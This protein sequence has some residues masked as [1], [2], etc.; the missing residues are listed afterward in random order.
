[1]RLA[2]LAGLYVAVVC[3]AQVSANKIVVLPVWH[4]SAPGGTY[5]VGVALALVEAVHR[6]AATRRDGWRNAQVVIALGFTA[7][8][9]LAG[10]LALVSHMT[11]AFPGQQF[12]AVL[13][14]TWR[15][16]AASLAAFAVSETLDNAL[17][18]W[19]RDRVP[20]ALRVIG[21]NVVSAPIDSL[22][23]IALAFGTGRL[24]L[25]KGQYVAKMEATVLIGLPLVLALRRLGHIVRA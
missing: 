15:I 4:L 24:G 16:V 13:G 23:F 20:D 3:T 19:S 8:A 5:A 21:T 18:A 10:Y 7:S 22:V 9:L 12:D 1:M 17:G 6:T 2:I 25:V 14:Q 11:P